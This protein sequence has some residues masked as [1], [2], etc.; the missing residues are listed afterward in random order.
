MHLLAAQPGGFV[1]DEGIIDLNQTPADIVMLSAADSALAALSEAARCA[2]KSEPALAE[3]ATETAIETPTNDALSV[4]LA[5]WMQLLKPAAYDLYEHKV[6]EQSKVV[7]LS[8]LGGASYWSYGLERLQKWVA[9]D[10]GRTLIIV[11]G[12]DAPDDELFNASSV[13]VAEAI[14]VWR[15]LREGGVD[16]AVQLINYLSDQYLSRPCLW[17]EPRPLPKCMI[18]LPQQAQASV[19][20]ASAIKA[21]T[22]AEWQRRYIPAKQPY[23]CD[24][25]DRPKAL[26]LFYR[27]HLQS[28]NTAMFDQLIE[29]FDAQGIAPLPIA[30][31]SLKDAESLA[32][33]NALLE[34]SGASLIINS[35]G[36]A[37]NTV[38]SPD[39]C[40]QPSEF[41]SPFVRQVPVLQLVLSSSTEEDWLTHSQGLRSRD[42]A[43]QVV[44]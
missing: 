30:I 20:A 13:A 15:Y 25:A 10:A 12:D 40:S 31:A 37:S 23:A 6:L 38:A 1:D 26:L 33:V 43:M 17:Q 28:G 39:L 41:Y 4:R 14:R 9:Q 16:N 34:Q 5:N 3:T 8:L 29:C 19:G 18:Y 36:F 35:T 24:G 2:I 44:L 22:F 7:V 21:S 11:P 27:S 32:L 42:I